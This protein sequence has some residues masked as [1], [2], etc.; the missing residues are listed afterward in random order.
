[1]AYRTK[2]GHMTPRRIN[3]ILPI[4]D[5]KSRF[6]DGSQILLVT[7]E[8]CVNFG[9]I[10][11]PSFARYP[12]KQRKSICRKKRIKEACKQ[13]LGC[14]WGRDWGSS[15]LDFSDRF[16]FPGFNLFWLCFLSLGPIEHPCRLLIN[17]TFPIFLLKLVC[18]G[19]CLL[20]TKRLLI[21]TPGCHPHGGQPRL[22]FLGWPCV[23]QF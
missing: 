23:T 12:E 3:H 20:T 17:S 16:L 4:Q 22:L 5:L 11:W 2:S 9:N 10:G 6:K 8:R 13:N 1:M 21:K 15:G 14:H 19:F 18:V 7:Y